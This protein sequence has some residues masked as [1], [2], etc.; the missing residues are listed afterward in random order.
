MSRMR[1][2]LRDPEGPVDWGVLRCRN[3]IAAD[4]FWQYTLGSHLRLFTGPDGRVRVWRGYVPC[5]GPKGLS[6]GFGYPRAKASR[7]DYL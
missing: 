4:Y 7:K 6:Y 5:R 3:L 2:A 1:S